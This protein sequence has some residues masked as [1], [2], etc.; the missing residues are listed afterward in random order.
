MGAIFGASPGLGQAG[1]NIGQIG[2]FAT[3][4]GES[5]LSQSNQFWSSILSGDQTKVAQALAPQIGAMQQQQQ[6]AQ[7]AA[8]QFQPRGGGTNA[9][10]QMAGDVTRGNISNLI[11]SLTSGAAGQL[12]S[13]G[14]GLLGTGLQ[15]FGQQAGIAQQQIQ[16][17]QNGLFG[18]AAGTA[19]GAG[20]GALL[21]MVGM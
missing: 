3:G 16:N 19:A 1:K 2:G 13:Q 15:A 12:G 11:S 8:A 21:G 6:Q 20:T 7:N 14:A 10:M 4:L 17:W 18:Q 9:A 5:G